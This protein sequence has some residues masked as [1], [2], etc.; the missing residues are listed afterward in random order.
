MY[1]AVSGIEIA[2]WDIVGKALNTPIYNLLGGKCREK[3]RVYANAWFRGAFTPEEYADKAVEAVKNGWSA[4]KFDPFGPSPWRLFISKKDMLV[5]LD[6]VRAVREAVGDKV[7]LLIEV[8]LARDVEFSERLFDCCSVSFGKDNEGM[9]G[10][11]LKG[12]FKTPVLDFNRE[13]SPIELWTEELRPGIL[14]DAIRPGETAIE[15]LF[16]VEV[17]WADLA[18]NDL[19][20]L[21][22][23]RP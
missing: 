6:R 14:P 8:T 18:A 3:L 2:L 16:T 10:Q 21:G 15:P 23:D 5:G 11:V 4:L 20:S 19:F 12:E 9:N 17:L 7:D 1:C 22:R 13:R